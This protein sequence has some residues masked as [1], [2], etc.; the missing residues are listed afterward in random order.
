MIEGVENEKLKLL[1]TGS[2]GLIGSAVVEYFDKLDNQIFGIDNNGRKEYF[3]DEGSTLWNLE[4]LKKNCRNFVHGN[5]DIRNKDGIDYLFSKVQFD[6]VLHFAA[7]PAHDYS[8]KNPYND[9]QV[10]TVG[11]VNLLEATRQYCPEAVFIFTSTSKVYGTAVNE[12]GFD[13]LE[14]RYDYPAIMKRFDFKGIN[15]DCRIDQ[16]LHSMFGANKAAADLICQEYG[17]YLNLNTVILRPGCL[18]G[19]GHSS[20]ELHGFLS[21]LIKCVVEKNTY[22]VFGYKMKQVRDNIHAYDIATICHEVLKKPPVP[23]TVFNVGGESENSIS[24][25]EAFYRLQ[26]LGYGPQFDYVERARK[27]DHIVYISDMSKFNKTYPNWTRK[28]NLDMIFEDI[29]R[30]FKDRKTI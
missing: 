30:G 6:A 29:I 20:V 1:V 22:K 13:E 16:T 18:T 4:R 3:G 5:L 10:N 8:F 12:Y 27:G 14:T 21:Y 23:G 7:Q 11:T 24:I 26:G 17:R 9:F 15:E 19:S 28:Y 2:N 25:I